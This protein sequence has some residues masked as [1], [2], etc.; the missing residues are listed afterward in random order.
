[1]KD[2]VAT[3]GAPTTV[4][5]LFLA[6][7]SAS[8][9]KAFAAEPVCPYAQKR[10]PMDEIL[11]QPLAERPLLC[12]A[13]LTKANLREADL[14][15]ANLREA[16]LAGADLT[17]ADLRLADLVGAVLRGADLR[18]ANLTWATL[19]NADFAGANLIKADLSHAG[20]SGADFTRANLGGAYL[21]G[22]NL[23]EANLTQANLTGA[24]LVGAYLY[25]TN[26]DGTDL[27]GAYLAS[28]TFEPDPQSLNSVVGIESAN[29][30]DRMRFLFSPT[31]L[32]VLRARFAKAG[33]RDQEREV[34]YAKLRSQQDNKWD[35]FGDFHP[36]EAAFSYLAF[37]L[38]CKY[39]LAYG[40]PLKILGVMILLLAVVYT[41][42]L[43]G[44]GDG[45]L[46]RVWQPDRIQKDQ[47][48]SE[49]ERLSWAPVK[50]PN[51]SLRGF[52]FRLWRALGFGLYFSLLS[53]FRIGWCEF[54]GGNWITRLHPREY[55]LRATGWVRV[56]S[57]VQSLL[58]LYL[59]TLW[60]LTYFGRPFE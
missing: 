34:N 31:A 23:H 25:G 2:S 44:R 50:V 59:L 32:I 5:L 57:A 39:G 47:G 6:L 55:T 7:L 60:A 58:S 30:L 13:D 21:E 29:G 8:P 1:M 9:G 51:R 3:E 33:F 48:Q 10:P 17:K 53:A 42:A 37:D 24:Y 22:A 36:L 26:L 27:T 52:L 4:L 38:T 28:V 45:A 41:I 43:H 19:F 14:R 56:V 15:E 40:R 20:F 18:G 35:L 54:S 12:K 11:T 16:N 49:P 46:R